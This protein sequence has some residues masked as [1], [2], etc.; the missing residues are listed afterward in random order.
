MGNTTSGT[1]YVPSST[2]LPVRIG[3][4]SALATSPTTLL[5]IAH[6]A[7]YAV[8]RFGTSAATLS[9]PECADV[10]TIHPPANITSCD[11]V[12]NNGRLR[13]NLAA[14]PA[15]GAVVSLAADHPAPGKPSLRLKN[16]ASLSNLQTPTILSL[17]GGVRVAPSIGIAGAASPTTIVIHLPYPSTFIKGNTSVPFL[18]KADC[19][20]ALILTDA[21]IVDSGT[22][23]HVSGDTLAVTLA[24]AYTLQQLP[25]VA[26]NPN[27]TLLVAGTTADDSTPYVSTPGANVVANPVLGIAVAASPSTIQITLPAP[28]VLMVPTGNVSSLSPTRCGDIL[29][30]RSANGTTKPLAQ[31]SWSGS[32]S[33]LVFTLA[34][35]VSYEVRDTVAL[36]GPQLATNRAWLQTVN[37]SVPY[38]PFPA[39]P[40]LPGFT[41]GPPLLVSPNTVWL[42]TPT[43]VYLSG[44]RPLNASDCA[45]VVS[46]TRAE[47]TGF[48]GQIDVTSQPVSSCRA[49]GNILVV[50]LANNFLDG[51]ECNRALARQ[52]VGNPQH[53]RVG[54]KVW[55]LCLTAWR[56]PPYLPLLL[57]RCHSNGCRTDPMRA[58]LPKAQICPTKQLPYAYDGSPTVHCCPCH[59][60]RHGTST[61]VPPRIPRVCAH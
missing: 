42:P 34:A 32:T 12:T 57:C 37:G 18:N 35:G 24:S 3:L 47:P 15:P 54:V 19:E 45:R 59:S 9:G 5:L 10:V 49:E 14:P 23:C 38:Q 58:P 52:A 27:N 25:T 26:I 61:H 46:V 7:F 8:D 4:H 11:V 41:D 22:A 55:R 51:G 13:V 31:C 56:W 29:L 1:P 43:P 21:S 2:G 36:A 17:P 44:G 30:V 33:A 20:T 6:Q 48:P 53:W 39:A 50:T 16:L 40:I 28:S 60:S